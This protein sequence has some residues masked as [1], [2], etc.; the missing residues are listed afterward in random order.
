MNKRFKRFIETTLPMIVGFG[1]VQ[2]IV[3]HYV[4]IEIGIIGIIIFAIVDVVLH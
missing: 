2:V 3:T 1:L 4:G